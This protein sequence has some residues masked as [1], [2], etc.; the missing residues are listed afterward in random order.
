MDALVGIDLGTSATKGVLLAADGRVLARERRATELLRPAPDRVEFSAER[1]YELLCEVVRALVGSTPAGVQ[2]RAIALSGATGNALLLDE[3]GAPLGNAISWLDGRSLGDPQADPPGLASETIRRT[4]GW[5]YSRR[6]PL[7]QL[8]WMRQNR[9]ELFG[10]AAVAAMNITHLYRRLSGECGMD[11]STA[12]TFYLQDQVER[13]WHRPLLEWLGLDEARLP[14]LLPSGAVLGRVAA[15]A[16]EETGLPAGAAVVM[17]AFDHPSAARGCG[18]LRPGQMLLSCGTSW[19]GFYPVADREAALA[20]KLLV[21]PFLS[22]RGPW[23]ALFSLPRVGEKVQALVD[24]T[25]AGEPTQAAR[26]ARFN[27]AAARSARGSAEPCRA[28]MEGIA[29]EMKSRME[30]LSAAGLRAE[31][32]AVVGGPT[33]SPAWMQI[34]SDL[35]GL[36]LL[37]PEVGAHAGAAGAAI[38]AGIGAGIFADEADGAARVGLRGRTVRPEGRT[39]G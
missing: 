17:G 16:A 2:V 25:F 28:L 38:L 19:V 26:Y 34:L 7:A 6:F 27:E 4:V 36:E 22:P 29:R 1:S 35:S 20:Q 31:R 14:R 9:P 12:T 15:R 8:S 18:V 32:I 39:D 13:R 11:H 10:R 24:E 21:D 5:P 23:G 3:R 37:L 33:E 30:S